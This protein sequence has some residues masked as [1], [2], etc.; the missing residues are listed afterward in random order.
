MDLTPSNSD[1]KAS[2]VV[3]QR[4]VTFFVKSKQQ[5]IREKEGLKPNKN[6]MAI[7]QQLRRSKIPKPEYTSTTP[8]PQAQKESM[9]AIKKLRLNFKCPVNVADFLVKLKL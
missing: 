9:E 3:L 7:P 2:D 5:I 6:S 4:I 1:I 8:L